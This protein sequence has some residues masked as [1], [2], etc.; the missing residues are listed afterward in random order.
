MAA[1][2]TPVAFS[3]ARVA[4]DSALELTGSAWTACS[5]EHSIP[6]RVVVDDN[7]HPTSG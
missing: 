5:V 6:S 4:S 1:A 2:L 3:R 7:I